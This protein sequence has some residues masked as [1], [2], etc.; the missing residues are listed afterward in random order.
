VYVAANVSGE[1]SSGGLF[2]LSTLTGAVRWSA[3]AGDDIHSVPAV[4]DHNV[5]I[6]SI[7]STVHAYD[8]QTGALQWVDDF[9]G[10]EIW[11]SVASANGVLYLDTDV[12]NAF[13]LDAMTGAV[14]WSVDLSGH[15]SFADMGSPAVVHGQVYVPYG[16][17]GLI[18]YGLPVG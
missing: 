13:A 14:L 15:G 8:A 3:P 12:D 16:G 5:Y 6:G 18:A 10:G 4:D 2:A 17:S 1:G 9:G 11:S 7:G